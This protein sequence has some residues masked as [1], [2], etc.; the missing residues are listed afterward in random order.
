MMRT[1]SLR[2]S[3]M[4]ASVHE[5]DSRRAAVREPAARDE[6]EVALDGYQALR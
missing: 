1:A 4:T 6:R 3:R 5:S 2:A